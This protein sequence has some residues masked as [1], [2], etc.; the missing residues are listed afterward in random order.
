MKKLEREPMDY[1]SKPCRGEL[2]AVLVAGALHIVTE[3]LFSAAA[4]TAYNVAVSLAFAGYLVWR[5]RR[6]AG[7]LRAWGMRVDNLRRTIPAYGALGAVG[8]A[9]L[10]AYGLLSG[11]F[12]LPR[13]FWMTVALYP[14]WGIAQQFALQSLVARNLTGLFAS[15]L[16]LAVA[17]AGLFALAHYPRWELV[18]LTFVAGVFLTLVYR[19]FPNLWAVGTVHGMLG[20]L[21]FYI[22]L[23]E[24]P[25]GV[26][27]EFLRGL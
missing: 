4:A 12:S 3:L 20:S 25:G 7:A 23:K 5:A 22:V 13:T 10:A 21:A 15:P 11:G 27:L 16:S 19:R 26:I 1:A 24:D 6:S 2:I 18:A 14:I 8:V 9:V 17:A